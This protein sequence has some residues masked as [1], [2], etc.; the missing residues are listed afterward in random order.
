L[1]DW[2]I[3]VENN[4]KTSIIINQNAREET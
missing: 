1:D 3:K 4:S 2:D